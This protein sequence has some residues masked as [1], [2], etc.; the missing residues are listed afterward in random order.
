MTKRIIDGDFRAKYG[1]WALVAGASEG[2]GAEYATQLAARGLNLVLIARRKELLEQLGAQLV[3]E[4]AIEVRALPLD[5]GRENTGKLVDAAT[6]DIEIGLLLYNAALSII[7]PYLETSLEDLLNEIAVNCRAPLS[8]KRLPRSA[9]NPSSFR[10]G[11]TAW[12]TL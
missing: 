11:Q 10:A 7:G 5:L 4:H 2:L 1:L 9:N 6:A 8:A 3:R 12:Q